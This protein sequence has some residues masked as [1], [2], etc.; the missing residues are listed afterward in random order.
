MQSIPEHE[1]VFE[2]EKCRVCD[3]E[4]KTMTYKGEGVCGVICLKKW[5]DENPPEVPL[6][7]TLPEIEDILDTAGV[8]GKHR[9]EIRAGWERLLAQK[10]PH[11]VR[12]VDTEGVE[13]K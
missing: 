12:I 13:S 2:H 1:D 8:N 11:L 7:V 9:K 6:N 10:M 5:Q 4:I 3:K